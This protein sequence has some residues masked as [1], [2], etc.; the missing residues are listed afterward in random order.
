[1]LNNTKHKIQTS[2]LHEMIDDQAVTRLH[3]EEKTAA[4]TSLRN[5]RKGVERSHRR[6]RR[7]AWNTGVTTSGWRVSTW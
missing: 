7:Y 5:Q 6:H 1:M 4:N 2:D 3:V